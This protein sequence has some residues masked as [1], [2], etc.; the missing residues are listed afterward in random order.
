VSALAFAAIVLIIA[1]SALNVPIAIALGVV[2]LLLE[3]VHEVWA[4]RGLRDVR[5]VRRL[6]NRRTPWGGEIPMTIEVWNRRRL[7]LAW[8]RAEDEATAGMIVR[9]RRLEP[10]ETPGTEVLRNAWTLRPFERV[11]RRFHVT[12]DRRG[13]Y[14]LGPVELSSGDPFARRA[15]VDRR[16][17]S[18][19][20][21][22]WP[23]TI[24]TIELEPPD[25]W[26]DLARARAGLAEDPS[27]FAGVR[28]YAPGDPVRRIHARTSARLGSPV[29][30]RFEPSR[31]REVLIV[32]DVQTTEGPTW[33]A[34][35][36]SDEVEAMYVVAA[37]IARALGER[38]V[39]FG[40]AAAGYT[41]TVTPFASVPVSSAPGQVERVLDL[42]ARL[43][44]H[45]S[46]PFER[47]LSVVDRT[48]GPGTTVLV[49]TTRDPRRFSAALR[50]LERLGANVVIVACGRD[51]ARHAAGAR[52][53][54][55]TVRRA[56]MDAHWRTAERLVIAP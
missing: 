21:L 44:A 23:R 11:A 24:P 20:F 51:P 46:A 39:A 29:T 9:E 50:R 38:R 32:V 56:W 25:H 54:G 8:L 48:V 12:S 4:R 5:Y 31:E 3:I 16:Q 36:G 40:L 27:R 6:A 28:P 45:A 2:T 41:G 17:V 13:V 15:A 35:T 47:L 18:D 42:L 30:K 37:S 19:Q 26:G 7:P 34:I 1:G 10:G 53:A 33:A 43:S 49:L 14:R 55:F 22:V 52:A